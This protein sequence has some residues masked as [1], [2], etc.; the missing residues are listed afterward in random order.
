MLGLMATNG[1]SMLAQGSSF[2][3][4]PEEETAYCLRVF[5]G[6]PDSPMQFLIGIRDKNTDYGPYK[7]LEVFRVNRGRQFNKPVILPASQP[8]VDGPEVLADFS[9]SG[10]LWF[11]R[12]VGENNLRI[13]RVTGTEVAERELQLVGMK[14]A[15]GLTPST[16]KAIS[17]TEIW[18]AGKQDDKGI[19]VKLHDLDDAP[20][21]LQ[22][23]LPFALMKVRPLSKN[24]AVLAGARSGHASSKGFAMTTHLALAD[25]DLRK[26]AAQSPPVDGLL[27]DVSPVGSNFIAALTSTPIPGKL[28]LHLFTSALAFNRSVIL[29]EERSFTGRAFLISYK[30]LVIAFASNLGKCS[31]AV[32]EPN[33][34]RLVRRE[35][36]ETG[37]SR[38]V[39]IRA[40]GNGS[41]VLL[42]VTLWR[43]QEDG[44]RVGVQATVR[45]LDDLVAGSR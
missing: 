24:E 36:I 45:S 23:A 30:E 8:S 14:G 34:G 42:A 39:D 40:A 41:Q 28:S 15:G 9:P 37:Q 21:I 1:L 5:W 17:D 20:E 25:V 7:R 10:A 26:L 18:L 12:P 31:I 19:L 35:S 32:I 27:L 4:S 3:Y 11:A 43:L 22:V 44:F 13:N 16:L 29:L 6:A 38:C 2:Q 33:T